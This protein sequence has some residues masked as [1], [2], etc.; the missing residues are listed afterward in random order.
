MVI[1][2]YDIMYICLLRAL[3]LGIFIFL[4]KSKAANEENKWKI[5]LNFTDLTT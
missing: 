1:S 4:E 3:T 2:H 5:N